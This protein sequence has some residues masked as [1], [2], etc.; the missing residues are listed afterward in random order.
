MV[1]VETYF[2]EEGRLGTRRDYRILDSV[3]GKELGAGTR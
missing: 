2:A 1:T 3:T